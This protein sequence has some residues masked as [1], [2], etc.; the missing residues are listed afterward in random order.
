ML[1]HTDSD[2]VKALAY[3]S[4]IRCFASAGLDKSMMLALS[5]PGALPYSCAVIYLWDFETGTA[6]SA[7]EVVAG[8]SPLAGHKDSIYSLAVNSAGS[9]LV[10]GSTENVTRIGSICL[11]LIDQCRWFEC[12]IPGT[13]RR[14]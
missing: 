3:A 7:I 14:P 5:P 13:A 8:R 9:R 1:R 4:K 6:T 2:Y 10:S 12:G 11:L